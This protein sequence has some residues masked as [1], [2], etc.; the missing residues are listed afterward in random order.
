MRELLTFDIG[1]SRPSVGIFSGGELQEVCSL[2]HFEESCFKDLHHYSYCLSQVGK[3]PQV[4]EALSGTKIDLR[5]HWGSQN[6]FGM[7]TTYA[8]TLGDDRLYTSALAWHE[9]HSKNKKTALV[10]DL[11]TFFTF[12]WVDSGRGHLGGIIAPGLSTYLNNFARGELLTVYAPADINWKA[13]LSLPSDT[14][15]AITTSA[16]WYFESMLEKALEQAP[17]PEVIYLTGGSAGVA[18]ELLTQMSSGAEL[19]LDFHF[20]HRAMHHLAKLSEN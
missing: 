2:G 3:P 20:I 15:S 16:R 7:P 13:A 18:K 11:G 17:T 14:K 1:N 12:D 9:L 4:L 19:I 10:L 6:F 5:S 8:H